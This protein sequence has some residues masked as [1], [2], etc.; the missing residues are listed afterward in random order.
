MPLDSGGTF[1]HNDQSASMHS[2]MS[3]GERNKAKD[4]ILSGKKMDEEPKDDGEHTEVHNHGDGTFHTVHGG[5]ETEHESIGHMH[6]HLS[7]LHGKPE[8]KHFHAHSDG[9]EAHSHSTHTGGEPEHEAHD[10]EDTEGM[11]GHLDRAMGEEAQ[12]GVS[13][14]AGAESPDASALGY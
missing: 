8:E 14:G 6:A 12:E 3:G 10:G 7:S 11:H 5:E 1:R 13:D 4:D 2:K 9:F